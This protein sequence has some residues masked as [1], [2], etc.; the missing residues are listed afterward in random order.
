[1]IDQ[2]GIYDIDETLYHADP[3]PGGSL[4]S[5]QVRYLGDCP[6]RFVWHRH[7]P[8]HSDA[9][10][11]GKAAHAHVLDVGTDID[12]IDAPDWRSKDSRTARDESR[13]AGRTPIL[14]K[15]YEQVEAMAAELRRHPIAAALLDPANGKPEQSAFWHDRVWRRCRF[16]WL[17]EVD[18]NRRLIIADY[19]T[20]PDA[21]ARSFA[22]AAARFGYHQQAAWY[23]DG[24]RH[25]LDVAE[26]A[27]VFIV[28][29]KNPPYLVNV[30][31][32]DSYAIQ[33]GAALNE[34]AVD[35][36]ERAIETGEWP[37]YG[38][39]VEQVSLPRWAEIAFEEGEQA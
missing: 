22:R 27:F 5:T 16:D 2:P 25:T 10:D 6:A 17:P 12:E 37:G 8:K 28:Q 26:P 13:A 7:N 31:E 18:P 20:A 23:L 3:V 4:S 30:V 39:E 32:L 38:T 14:A 11:F 19:K 35:I 34:R 21:D 15:D 29:E 24:A 9:F 36:Y 33:I 1:M